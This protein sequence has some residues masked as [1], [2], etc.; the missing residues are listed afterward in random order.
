MSQR[1]LAKKLDLNFNSMHGLIHRAQQEEDALSDDTLEIKDKGNYRTVSGVTDRIKSEQDLIEVC[2]IDLEVW[3]IEELHIKTWE[4]YRKDINKEFEIDEGRITGHV[5]DHG[6]INTKT[7]YSV[8]AKLVK[9]NPVPVKP[10]VKPVQFR[11]KP[12][13]P[14][15]PS[16]PRSYKRA[17]FA[18]DAHF[19]FSRD[20]F[21]GELTNYHCRKSLSIILAVVKDL[22]FDRI[23]IGGDMLDVAEWS[24][25]FVRGPEMLL[26]TQPAVYEL[27]WWLA[28]IGIL[29][30]DSEKD[31]LEGNHEIRVPEFMK[32]HAYMMLKL[33]RSTQ[34]SGESITSVPY[35]LD[36]EELG[37]NWVGNY[38]DGKV[39]LRPDMMLAH[40]KAMSAKPG[41]TA[42]VV[43][44]KSQ[45][46]R[47]VGHIHRRELATKNKYDGDGVHSITAFSPGCLCKI[48]G[49]VPG[50]SEEQ[51]WQNGF[52]II[53]YNDNE[54]LPPQIVPIENDKAYYNGKFYHAWDY[55]DELSRDT[56]NNL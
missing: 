50:S 15:K 54:L 53:E 4:G 30:P 3:Q 56:E 38:P 21:T 55:G 29:S 6:G 25:K 33:R 51:N 14:R 37:Y 13:R 46:S 1:E 35:I 20:V 49:T 22:H 43:V 19:G 44:E 16:K 5:S 47:G 8:E 26:T 40:G 24:T 17:L 28:Q 9:R 11:I 12:A 32:A 41:G 27:G 31:Y 52:G 18:T 7:M 42:S 2:K 45:V 34:F 36:L 10:M 48:D 23:V 39:W